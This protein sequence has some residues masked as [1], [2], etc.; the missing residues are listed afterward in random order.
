[1]KRLKFLLI[2][3]FLPIGAFAS[4]V[5]FQSP[6]G[7]IFCNG[8]DGF[9]G[10]FIGETNQGENGCAYVIEATAKKGT[11]SC[12]ADLGNIENQEIRTLAYGESIQG[13]G[14][15]CTSK[16]TGMHCVNRDGKGFALSRAKQKL[17]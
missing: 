3:T 11:K 8:S 2:G 7:N 9:V 15:T 10:C 14:W 16:S 6:S 17:F 1:M 5:Y 12:A 13:R 4:D